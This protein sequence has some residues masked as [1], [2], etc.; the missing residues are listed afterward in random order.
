LRHA[1]AGGTLGAVDTAPVIVTTSSGALRG[2]RADGVV[3]YRG[4][5]YAA[6]PVGERRFGAPAPV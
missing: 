3:A 5:P 4:I 6:T 1:L 2:T